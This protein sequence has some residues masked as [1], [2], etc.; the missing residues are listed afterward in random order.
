MKYAEINEQRL[1]L[2]WTIL[3]VKLIFKSCY[4]GLRFVNV[5]YNSNSVLFTEESV[6]L[7]EIWLHA[8]LF[9]WWI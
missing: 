9:S 1:R 2:T 6:F 4:L 8:W 7:K 5:Q 3:C